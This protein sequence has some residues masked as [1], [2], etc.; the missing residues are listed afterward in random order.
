M[1]S[2]LRRP[3]MARVLR[4]P[5]VAAATSTTTTA[6][7]AGAGTR[8]I[9]SVAPQDRLAVDAS[10]LSSSVSSVTPASAAVSAAAAVPPLPLRPEAGG[11][12]HTPVDAEAAAAR[13]CRDVKDNDELVAALQRVRA[14]LQKYREHP[15]TTSS[16]A[17]ASPVKTTETATAEATAPLLSYVAAARDT[18]LLASVVLLLEKDASFGPRLL[19]AL[20]GDSLR[21]AL[22]IGTAQEYFGQDAVEAQLRAVDK[23]NDDN[24]SSQEYD[25]WV[26]SAVRKRAA[27]RF[28]MPR[29]NA[30]P[31]QEAA[32]SS[33]S[34]S[35][36]WRLWYHIA[37]SAAVPFMAFGMLDNTI[38]V[39]VGDTIDKSFAEALG[40]STMAAAALGGVVSGTAGIQMH[41]LADRMTQRSRLARAPK[42]TA[43]QRASA[44]HGSAARAG[45]TFG[46][47]LGLVLG[48]TPLLLLSSPAS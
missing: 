29:G 30:M 37:W 36:S 13:S 24:I 10:P 6:A 8:C 11:I 44:S 12:P 3:T 32:T 1:W 15:P 33:S 48:M 39:T 46:M 22:V 41:G 43:A 45:S 2:L 9:S 7:A 40:L 4:A 47:M 19:A 34:G 23:D 28:V 14:A 35:V 17:V 18:E 27:T 26:E 16:C 21:L 38:F 5:P 25:A 31:S 20:P 42:L